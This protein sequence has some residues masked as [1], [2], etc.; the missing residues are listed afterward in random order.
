MPFNMPRVTENRN[1]IND[2][3]VPKIIKHPKCVITGLKNWYPYEGHIPPIT[4]LS[5]SADKE[6]F[7]SADYFKLNLWDLFRVDTCYTIADF[8]PKDGA[9]LKE[10]VTTIDTHPLYSNIFIHGSNLGKINLCDM[11]V[12]AI[13]QKPSK[14]FCSIRKDR[15]GQTAADNRYDE[16]DQQSLFDEVTSGI[17][18]AKFSKGGKY[19]VTRDYMTVK[20]WDTRYEK[21]PFETFYVHEYLREGMFELYKTEQL[22]DAFGLGLSSKG[23]IVTGTYSN[24]FHLFELSER[25][26][27]FINAST[28]PEIISPIEKHNKR[29]DVSYTGPKKRNDKKKTG[30]MFNMFGKSKRAKAQVEDEDIPEKVDSY[31]IKMDFEAIEFDK[32]VLD[33]A[34]HPSA[35]AVAVTAQNSLFIYSK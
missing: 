9:I 35:N 25:R 8:M 19:I 27:V 3:K 2:L 30:G 13:A 29:R 32:K 26:D 31:P 34:W 6:N 24:Y 16:D 15:K 20:I 23:D 17:A 7:I 21:R 33:C 18:G 11:R 10:V 4:H 1:I 12:K 28:E 5:V 22:A 14:Q